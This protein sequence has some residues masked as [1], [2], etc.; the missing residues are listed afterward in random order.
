[1]LDSVSR[2]NKQEANV[3]LYNALR[4]FSDI[5][6]IV[7]PAAITDRMIGFT[8]EGQTKVWV[9]ENFG[10]N[11]PNYYHPEAKLNEGEV[12]ANLVNAVA[13]RT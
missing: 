10:M 6:R 1:M 12:V 3:V 2:L 4:G 8:K 11:Y 9:N 5:S 13:P 7:V